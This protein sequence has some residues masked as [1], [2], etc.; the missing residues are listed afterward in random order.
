MESV[1]R[2]MGGRWGDWSSSNGK[3]ARGKIVAIQQKTVTLFGQRRVD[4]GGQGTM[5]RNIKADHKVR[6][7]LSRWPVA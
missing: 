1:P 2:W 4:G 5:M 7:S 3:G 6:P